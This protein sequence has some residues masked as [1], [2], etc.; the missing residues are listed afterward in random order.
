MNYR[1]ENN[2]EER[3]MYCRKCRNLLDDTDQYCRKCGEPT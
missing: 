2:M 1:S 3:R